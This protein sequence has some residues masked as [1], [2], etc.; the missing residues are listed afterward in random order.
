[1][2][3]KGDDI[4]TGVVGESGLPE[5]LAHLVDAGLEPEAKEDFVV[6]RETSLQ[7]SRTPDGEE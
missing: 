1:V 7:S 2:V 6:R 4:E 3:G 5:H